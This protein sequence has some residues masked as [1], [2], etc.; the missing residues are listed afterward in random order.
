MNFS[1]YVRQRC[2]NV[3]PAP[4]PDPEIFLLAETLGA[5]I[6]QG[7]GIDGVV[8]VGKKHYAEPALVA[9]LLQVPRSTGRRMEKKRQKSSQPITPSP[10]SQEGRDM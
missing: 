6:D 8:T 7:E 2:M 10:S 3:I 9:E 1:E 5:V 4:N